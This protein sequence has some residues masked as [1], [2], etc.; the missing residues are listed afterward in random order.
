MLPLPLLQDALQVEPA[1]VRLGASLLLLAYAVVV[2]AVLPREIGFIRSVD[3]A[4]WRRSFIVQDVIIQLGVLLVLVPCVLFPERLSRE[5]WPY[6]VIISGVALLWGG[7]LWAALSRYSYTYRLLTRS[8]QDFEQRQRE[9]IE[10]MKE[11]SRH[12]K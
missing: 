5:L 2:M 4:F 8:T 7:W 9:L 10:G 1:Q 12:G 6:T 11:K 3:E